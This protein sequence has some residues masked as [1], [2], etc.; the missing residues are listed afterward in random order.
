MIRVRYRWGVVGEA[1]RVVH[2]A[3]PWSGRVVRALCGAELL[4]A[5][6]ERV[7]VGGMPCMQCTARAAIAAEE[8][9]D[10]SSAA[11]LVELNR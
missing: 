6:I 5:E 10:P 11:G 7:D 8:G 3:W 9:V 1:R 2:V 4:V